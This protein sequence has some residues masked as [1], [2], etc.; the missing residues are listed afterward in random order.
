V[1][2]AE[3]SNS[4]QNPNG[5][6]EVTTVSA[7]GPAANAGIKVG[8]VLTRINNVPL[9]EP[10]DLIALVRKY[11]PGQAVTVQYQRDGGPHSVQVT[12]ASSAN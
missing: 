8:D 2:G 1:I 12:L 10:A 6:V 9:N 4:Y 7:G 5:G 11:A 3:L